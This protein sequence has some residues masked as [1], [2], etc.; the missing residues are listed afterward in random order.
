MIR[1]F[2]PGPSRG[3]LA[4]VFLVP[5]AFCGATPDRS[6]AAAPATVTAD[7]VTVYSRMVASSEGIASL[8]RGDRV[9]IDLMLAGPGGIWCRVTAAAQPVTG[10]VPCEVLEQEDRWQWREVRRASRP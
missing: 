5:L 2:S 8:K 1:Q 10:Y 6:Q 9:S 7:S 3:V 4:L